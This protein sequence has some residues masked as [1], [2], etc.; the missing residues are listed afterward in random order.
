MS[1]PW[2]ARVRWPADFIFEDAFWYWFERDPIPSDLLPLFCIRPW[3]R[4]NV[5]GYNEGYPYLI[6]TTDNN[7]SCSVQI[8][9]IAS[10]F[11]GYDYI[12]TTQDE[13]Y[14]PL[15]DISQLKIEKG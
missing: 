3:K 2:Q 10:Y 8:Y 6:W 12:R 5:W 14:Y 1:C 11:N 15:P 4:L 9:Q 13:L 7:H